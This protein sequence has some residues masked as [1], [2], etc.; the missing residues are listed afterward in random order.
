LAREAGIHADPNVAVTAASDSTDATRDAIG[1]A[2]AIAVGIPMD[3]WE[4]QQQHE[5]HRL[6][7]KLRKVKEQHSQ[8]LKWTRNVNYASRAPERV[9]QKDA[10]KLEGLEEEM[11]RAAAH[12][13]ST[14][15]ASSSSEHR[16]AAGGGSRKKRGAAAVPVWVDGNLTGFEASGKGDWC[17]C[18]CQLP[19]VTKEGLHPVEKGPKETEWAVSAVY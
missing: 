17:C 1:K 8:L 18:Y 7:K 19:F 2:V 4:Q 10:L 6:Q 15:G 13:T 14:F 12:L 16:R 9:Q 5:L 11:T 3:G